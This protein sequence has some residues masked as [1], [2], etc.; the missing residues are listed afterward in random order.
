MDDIKVGDLVRYRNRNLVFKNLAVAIGLVTELTYDP[1]TLRHKNPILCA[2]V[3]WNDDK[4]SVFL[5]AISELEVI[6]ESR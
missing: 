3:R 2:R 5:E 6:S 1:R 4:Q